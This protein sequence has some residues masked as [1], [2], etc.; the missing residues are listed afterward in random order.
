MNEPFQL[1]NTPPHVAAKFA[2]TQTA[3]PNIFTGMECLPGQQDLPL[4]TDDDYEPALRIHNNTLEVRY[5]W[6]DDPGPAICGAGPSRR[7]R[8]IVE[9]VLGSVVLVLTAQDLERL[10]DAG[11]AM[12]ELADTLLAEACEDARLDLAEYPVS[13]TLAIDGRFATLTPQRDETN[14][15]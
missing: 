5:G 7:S 9:D 4:S 12:V 2:D 15:S 1:S 13:W 14:P 3:Q 8:R 6:W 10:E 11:D